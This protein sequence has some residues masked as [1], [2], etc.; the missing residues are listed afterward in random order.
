MGFPLPLL[1]LGRY[2]GI[3]GGSLWL[4]L[5]QTR[6]PNPKSI[7]GT[8]EE[9]SPKE[10]HGKPPKRGINIFGGLLDIHTPVIR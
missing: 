8:Y 7:G 4:F 5:A 2:L 3:K 6:C 9:E 10:T 1:W